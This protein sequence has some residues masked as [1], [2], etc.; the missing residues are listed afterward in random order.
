M[1]L[2]DFFRAASAAIAVL[3]AA[4][5]SEKQPQAPGEGVK[6]SYDPV[7][8]IWYCGQILDIKSVLYEEVEEGYVFYLSP[9]SGITDIAGME[10]KGDFLKLET[11]SSVLSDG[12]GDFSISYR[13]ISLTEVLVRDLKAFSLD[14]SFK[15]GRLEFYV[16]VLDSDG[17]EMVASYRGEVSGAQ[18]G[19]ETGGGEQTLS[20]QYEVDGEVGNV[21]SVLD[22][23]T[24]LG[25][26]TYY[27]Y[28]EEG[29]LSPAQSFVPVIEISMPD[30]LFGRKTD[31]QNAGEVVLKCSGSILSG[32]LTG[33]LTAAEGRLGIPLSLE[34]S[35]TD[36]TRTVR[37]SYSGS[38]MAEYV[39]KDSF[40]VTPV[41]GQRVVRSLDKVFCRNVVTSLTFAF[42]D[43][44]GEISVPSDLKGNGENGACYAVSLTLAANQTGREIE[45]SGE[46]SEVGLTVYDYR[47]SATST[48]KNG[49]ITSGSVLVLPGLI[50]NGDAYYVKVSAVLADGTSMDAEYY[51]KVVQTVEEMDLAPALPDPSYIR[52]LN[53]DEEE[54]FHVAV[55]QLQVRK[56]ETYQSTL[57]GE[58]V[59]PAY[60]FYFINEMSD[61]ETD[62]HNDQACTPQLILSE[63]SLNL[64]RQDVSKNYFWNFLYSYKGGQTLLYRNGYCS[65]YN[66][67]GYC[68]EGT[69]LTSMWNQDKS[70]D[71]VF[72]MTDATVTWGS[73][74][75]TKNVITMEWHG[76]ASL[77]RGSQQNLLTES[78]LN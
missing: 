25:G 26:R 29:V 61:P 6:P 45:F 44:A 2:R 57:S 54:L 48:L 59:S 18:S 12:T 20:C 71:V 66:G 49:G 75:G 10:R 70:F 31:L 11:S 15:D 41:E 22:W 55:T 77:Y 36:G 34:L 72:R 76:K 1:G 51:G 68:P 16:W 64:N 37:L 47:N 69:L 8:R 33:S 19:G 23:R 4:G 58:K 39:A 67:F 35:A 50:S 42:G 5:C 30:N 32:N 24:P 38:P 74:T 52:V 60:F 21:G 62:P 14:F 63:A 53:S 13:K 65:I 28:K 46:S 27:I 7:D 43:A 73:V 78:D 17:L 56:A 40:E 9:S 3:M